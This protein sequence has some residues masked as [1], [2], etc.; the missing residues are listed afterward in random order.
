MYAVR[1][2]SDGGG[3]MSVMKTPNAP[4]GEQPESRFWWPQPQDVV[5]VKCADSDGPAAAAF[6]SGPDRIRVQ[7]SAKR[8]DGPPSGRRGSPVC[9]DT[10]ELNE[11]GSDEAEGSSLD[12]CGSQAAAVLMG[13]SPA[14]SSKSKLAS[15]LALVVLVLV[16]LCVCPSFSAWV[17]P[18]T[19]STAPPLTEK[20]LERSIY[21]G[22][23]APACVDSQNWTNGWIGCA[24]EAGGKDPEACK[25]G[26]WTCQAYALKGWCRNGTAVPSFLG[27]HHHY[28]EKHCCICGGGAGA[29]S[30]TLVPAVCQAHRTCPNTTEHCCPTPSGVWLECCEERPWVTT[31]PPNRSDASVVVSTTPLPHLA[32]CRANPSCPDVAAD[33]CPQVDG[34]W[35]TCCPGGHSAAPVTMPNSS[36]VPG[37]QRQLDKAKCTANPPCP[38]FH[39]SDCC[40]KTNGEWLACCPR[41]PPQFA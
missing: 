2:Y 35:H 25:P 15:A 21:V 40:P 5:E 33:C 34:R 24:V 10:G 14:C 19:R 13:H 22:F 29:N 31:S 4:N 32:A 8:P 7:E 17:A 37:L 26:G 16:A 41:R 18:R 20:Q 38:A 1:Q 39:G 6:P 28:P 9:E 30:S 36:A 12:G 11:S 23:P 27:E 3:A